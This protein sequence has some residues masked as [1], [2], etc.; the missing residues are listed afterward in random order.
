MLWNSGCRT[1]GVQVQLT[2]LV[3]MQHAIQPA[4]RESP[5]IER[6]VFENA[7]AT[8]KPFLCTIKLPFSLSTVGGISNALKSGS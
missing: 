5:A 2:V 8:A 1:M 4:A 3:L 6:A 7:A